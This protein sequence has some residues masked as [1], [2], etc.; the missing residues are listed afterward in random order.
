MNWNRIEGSWKQF[1]GSAKVRWGAL[2][3]S[4]LDV[5]AGKRAQE[6]GR[7]QEADATAR[8]AVEARHPRE[9]ELVKR[10]LRDRR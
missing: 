9:S 6:A 2:T 1:K 8:E 7:I 5:V 10:D 4:R 3:E